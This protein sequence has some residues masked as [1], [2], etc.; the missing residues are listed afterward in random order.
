MF[1]DAFR[2]LA[3]VV[4]GEKRDSLSASERLRMLFAL[5]DLG[6]GLNITVPYNPNAEL[7]EEWY[8]EQY[9]RPQGI[10]WRPVRLKDRWYEDAVGV[11]MATF[12]YSLSCASNFLSI[13]YVLCYLC[14]KP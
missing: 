9:F 3:G 10:M 2:K 7:N 12:L 5:E 8:R 11:M 1:E 6:K 14:P 4:T 13:V